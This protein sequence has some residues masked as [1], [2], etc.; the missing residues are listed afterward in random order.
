MKEIKEINYHP[1]IK[2]FLILKARQ[3]RLKEIAESGEEGGEVPPEE[4]EEVQEDDPDAPDL[5]AMITE[6]KEKLTAQR[7]SD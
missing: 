1:H 7:E 5:N 6:K 4:E 2:L 3:A